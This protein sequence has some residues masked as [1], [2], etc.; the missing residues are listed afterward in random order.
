MLFVLYDNSISGAPIAL[1]RLLDVLCSQG[2]SKPDVLLLN[3]VADGIDFSEVAS[4]V[5]FL[6][7]LKIAGRIYRALFKLDLRIS[8]TIRLFNKYNCVVF[9]TVLSLQPYNES[10][11]KK[12]KN[13]VLYLHEM[14]LLIRSLLP[15]YKERLNCFDRFLVPSESVANGLEE[16][17]ILNKKVTRLNTCL[18]DRKPSFRKRNAPLNFEQNHFTIGF[19]GSA[20]WPKGLDYF[21]ITAKYIQ[22]NFPGYKI[23]FRVKGIKTGTNE[24]LIY[25]KDVVKAE[26]DDILEIENTDLDIDT[27]YQRIDVLAVTSREDS[28]PNVVIEAALNQKPTICFANSGGASEFIRGYGGKVVPFLSVKEFTNAILSYYDNPDSLRQDGLRAEELAKKL[29]LDPKLTS[30]QFS[31][32]ICDFA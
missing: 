6:K 18:L 17:Q 13:K 19:L 26:M 14:P 25:A 29:H 28:Y 1:K 11:L 20:A 5:Y 8:R 4:K 10:V 2:K 30:S 21:F 7:E 15:A 27:F 12:I 23:H 22:E 32:S 9:N 16:L 31:E 3:K 24:D